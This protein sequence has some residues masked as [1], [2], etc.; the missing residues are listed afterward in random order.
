MVSVAPQGVTLSDSRD[1]AVRPHEYTHHE[2]T[3]F[4]DGVRNREAQLIAA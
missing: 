3:C 1:A 2:W 4:V